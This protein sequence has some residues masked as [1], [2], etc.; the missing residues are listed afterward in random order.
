MMEKV[1]D[2]WRWVFVVA[3]AEQAPVFRASPSSVT[4]DYAQA[5]SS[6]LVRNRLEVSDLHEDEKVLLL[7]VYASRPLVS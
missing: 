3:E 2:G 4:S 7:C 6:L 5:Q 1:D